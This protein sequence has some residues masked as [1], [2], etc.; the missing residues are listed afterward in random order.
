MK[1]IAPAGVSVSVNDDGRATIKAE[2]PGTYRVRVVDPNGGE[3]EFEFVALTRAEYE[4][5]KRA[6]A[7]PP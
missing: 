3:V 4:A 6:G 7:P 2:M 5:K 1:I